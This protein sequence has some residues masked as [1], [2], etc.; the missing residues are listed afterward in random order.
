[1]YNVNVVVQ[2]TVAPTL[3]ERFDT[4]MERTGTTR[5]YVTRDFDAKVIHSPV[6]ERFNERLP[7]D[8]ENLASFLTWGMKAFPAHNYMVVIKEHGRAFAG[9]KLPPS[10]VADA[11]ET[12]EKDNGKRV[13]VIAFD[14]CQM[15]NL[16]SAYE[17]KD[18]AKVMTGSPE[19]IYASDFPYHVFLQ[20]LEENPHNLSPADLGRLVVESHRSQ[21]PDVIES[22]LNL[23]KMK[24]MGAAVR[25]LVESIILEKIPGELIYTDMLKN[26]CD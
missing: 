11:L 1:M 2:A 24:D 17:L 22:A 26:R 6:V 10:D 12:V 25:D 14:S 21:K 16:E 19:E 9:S 7:A 13:G 18:H 5:Y 20:K 4:G 15:L 8:R 3:N 23:D